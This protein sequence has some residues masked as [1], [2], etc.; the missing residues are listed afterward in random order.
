MVRPRRGQRRIDAAIDHLSQYGFPRK[1]IRQTIDKLLSEKLYGRDGW[2]FLEENSYNIVVE[3]LLEETE[4]MQQQEDIEKHEGG[5]TS[6]EPLPENGIQTSEAQAPAA[7]SEVAKVQ[8]VPSELPDDANAVPLPVPPA[9]HITS[10]RCPC[11][12]WISESES[13][14]ELDSGVPAFEQANPPAILHHNMNNGVPSI[15][16]GSTP[17][18]TQHGGIHSKRRRSS[19]WDVPPSY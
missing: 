4:E 14:D 13:E 3:R 12:G 15:E 6:N 11:Y 9:R 2:V 19:R 16:E 17:R 7:A 10:T 8:A 18:E 5:E 1:L